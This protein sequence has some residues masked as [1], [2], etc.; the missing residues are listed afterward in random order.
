MKLK[1][2]LENIL[3]IKIENYSF[4]MLSKLFRTFSSVG[5]IR[6]RLGLS[7]NQLIVSVNPSIKVRVQDQPGS[8]AFS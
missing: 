8:C 7:L 3:F 5:L 6:C 4:V 1:K 2:L